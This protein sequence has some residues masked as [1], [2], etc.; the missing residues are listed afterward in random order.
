[1]LEGYLCIICLISSVKMSVSGLKV[2]RWLD[3]QSYD[4]CFRFNWIVISLTI[5]RLTLLVI[6]RLL[7]ERTVF[8]GGILENKKSLSLWTIKSF[9]KLF[10][11]W[12]QKTHSITELTGKGFNTFTML[13][14][15]V[16]NSSSEQSFSFCLALVFHAFP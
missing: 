10:V 3:L 16:Y 8:L 5:I 6:S 1:M 14:P 9:E 7:T 11:I 2:Y 12:N 4:T 15:F 13:H